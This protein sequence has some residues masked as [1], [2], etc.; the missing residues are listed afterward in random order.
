MD[1]YNTFQKKEIWG[2]RTNSLSGGP[3]LTQ[4]PQVSS[5]IQYKQF[6]NARFGRFDDA[7]LLVYERI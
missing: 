3:N 2:H 5:V 6:R 4:P 1:Y 7:I